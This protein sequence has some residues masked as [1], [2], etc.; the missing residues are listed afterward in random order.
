MA[1][2]K[3]SKILRIVNILNSTSMQP[4]LAKT[5]EG[6]ALVKYMGNRQGDISLVCELIGSAIARLV[7]LRTPDYC[8]LNCPEF[9]HHVLTKATTNDPAFATRWL[10]TA[11]TA[12]LS[13]NLFGKLRDRNDIA[14][15]IAFDTLVKNTDRFSEYDDSNCDNLLIVPDRRK[16]SLVVIDHGHIIIDPYQTEISID[17]NEWPNEEKIYGYHPLFATF[18]NQSSVDHALEAIEQVDRSSLEPI[19]SSIPRVWGIS[20]TELDNLANCMECR[21]RN[22][23]DWFKSSILDQQEFNF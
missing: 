12:S 4:L 1:D 10:D 19:F 11:T 3:P 18:L 16:T 20:D 5:D 2:W 6:L 13:E 23:K 7:G 15:L 8:I 21:A 17:A 9:Q 14:K 22:M